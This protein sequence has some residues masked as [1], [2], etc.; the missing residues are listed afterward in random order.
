MNRELSNVII[1][2]ELEKRSEKAPDTKELIGHIYDIVHE[3]SV[4]LSRV[5]DTFPEY[6]LH[7]ST[8]S[9]NVLKTMGRII[10][11]ETLEQMNELELTILIL[12]AFLHD[13]GMVIARQRKKE[14]LRRRDFSH[15]KEKYSRMNYSLRKAKEEGKYRIATQIEDQL[16][17][18]YLRQ[19]HAIRGAEFVK[20]KFGSKLKYHD[21]DFSDLLC[22]IC[23]S[24]GEPWEKLGVRRERVYGYPLREEYPTC[25][26]FGNFEIN[27]QFLAI[28]LR[29]ADILDFDRERTPS[30]LFE[31]LYPI[32]EISLSHWLT[33]L[34]VQ[35]WLIA[36]NKIRYRVE[37]EHPLYQKTVYEFL[38][39]VDGELQ[40][41]KLLMEKFP[42]DI[43]EKYKMHLPRAVDRS[44]IGPRIVGGKPSYI[45]GDFQ[46]GLDYDRVIALLVEELQYERS[47]AIR[48]LLQNSVDACR[49]RYSLERSLGTSWDKKKVKIHFVYDNNARTLTVED[50]GIGMDREIVR[51]HLLRVGCSYYSK[52]NPRYVRDVATF[53]E[54]GVS[55]YPISKFGIGILSCFLI[56]DRVLIKTRRKERNNLSN[57]L[58]IK[59]NPKLKMYVI[60]ELEPS[61]WDNEKE[62]GTVIT[63]YL[64]QPIDLQKFLEQFA[65]NVEFDISVSVDGITTTIKPKGFGL[66]CFPVTKRKIGDYLEKKRMVDCSFDLSRAKIEGVQ[67]KSTFFFPC[68]RGRMLVLGHDMES[69]DVTDIG[70]E[71]EIFGPYGWMGSDPRRVLH[72]TFATSQGIYVPKGFEIDLPFPHLTVINFFG[73]S[74]PELTLDRRSFKGYMEPLKEQIYDFL[75]KEI[76][77]GIGSR[78][79]KFY[80]P[81]WESLWHADN[82]I[83]EF[84]LRDLKAR[85]ELF[86][87]PLLIKGKV[88]LI[89]YGGIRKHYQAGVCIV[90]RRH[91]SA[92]TQSSMTEFHGAFSLSSPDFPL[93]AVA[94]TFERYGKNYFW[95]R[96]LDW[97][98]LTLVEDGDCY[99]LKIQLRDSINPI[100]KEMQVKNMDRDDFGN[101]R[102]AKYD[103][104]P[105]N[106][107]YSNNFAFALN[108][109]HPTVRLFRSCLKKAKS[110]NEIALISAFAR[111]FLSLMA[112]SYD[113]HTAVSLA[114]KLK[115]QKLI[116][117]RETKLF[118]LDSLKVRDSDEM[119][120]LFI[121]PSPI[122]FRKV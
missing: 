25:Y 39:K 51:N 72:K 26:L 59:I 15:F 30:V 84:F 66:D 17:T 31:Y 77:R 110:A 86:K 44:E 103:G 20:Q 23:Q 74:R 2:K 117:S 33:H 9:L 85:N 122:V 90:F 35:G 36:E 38:D 89:S 88:K 7:E 87:L 61:D 67:G 48:E 42:A 65:V 111:L 29:I 12:S 69:D 47:A 108:L 54:K 70:I 40:G 116:S 107:L 75:C 98:Q 64:T 49:Y 41:A 62:P 101:L 80:S 45:F 28:V 120:H 13:I 97:A 95:N 43:A 113:S 1:M 60:N 32:S 16:L 119:N 115:K 109:N 73:K 46:F 105:A 93:L 56:A 24:H 79:L 71:K 34:S 118:E 99:Y 5:T 37:C 58:S 92:R 6:T 21:L 27:A 22:K 96:L 18:F 114:K 19:S 78:K 81:F 83:Q 68:V 100:Y 10:P 94:P 104:I 50:N 91:K 82:D 52:D 63:L 11:K 106:I 3:A 55:F 14:I 8:H 121:D 112:E 102:F 53:R 4:L 57:P 76:R